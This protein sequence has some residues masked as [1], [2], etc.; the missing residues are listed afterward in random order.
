MAHPPATDSDLS[1]EQF[2]FL[3][4]DHNTKH[5]DRAVGNGFSSLTVQ[6]TLTH[7]PTRTHV[8][9]MKNLNH[10]LVSPRQLS[11]SFL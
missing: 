11:Y 4:G 8:R 9:T 2:L 1:L 10:F 5:P 3:T 7:S 6:F